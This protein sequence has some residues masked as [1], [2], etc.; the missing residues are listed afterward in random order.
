VLNLLFHFLYTDPHWV[1]QWFCRGSSKLLRTALNPPRIPNLGLDL[2]L[3]ADRP[4]ITKKLRSAMFFQTT[5]LR[6]GLE[7]HSAAQLFSIGV[8]P[9][10]DVGLDGITGHAQGDERFARTHPERD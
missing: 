8:V 7:N 2:G 1:W 9:A 5:A 6:C 10:C 4:S 3:D